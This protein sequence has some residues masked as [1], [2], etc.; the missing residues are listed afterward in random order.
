MEAALHRLF[1]FQAF[2]H[3]HSLQ[4]VIDAVHARC[5][6]RELDPD[7]ME[8]VS[9]A[10]APELEPIGGRDAPAPKGEGT[11]K[12]VPCPV[13]RHLNVMRKGVGIVLITCTNCGHT[14]YES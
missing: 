9:A 14:W 4:A 1:D 11:V 8:Y 3:N 13:C 10:G 7:D 12:V 2:E 6:V 5:A